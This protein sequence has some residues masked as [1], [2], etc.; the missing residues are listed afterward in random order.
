SDI[1][2]IRKKHLSR[3]GG[4]SYFE[5]YENRFDIDELVI[6]SDTALL[7]FWNAC[8]DI[9]SDL[10]FSYDVKLIDKAKYDL[11]L[12]RLRGDAF[13]GIKQGHDFAIHCLTYFDAIEI[14]PVMAR[15]LGYVPA[16]TWLKRFPE[17]AIS[18]L[19]AC[20]FNDVP[21]DR[22]DAQQ[23]LRWLAGQGYRDKIEHAAKSFGPEAH[24][25]A[26]IFLDR[27][28]EADFLPKKLAKL[29]AYFIA[30][31]HPA[32]ILKG[33]GKALPAHAVETIGR[34]M[35][36]S[37]CQLQTPALMQVMK[38]CDPQSLADFVLSAY[39]SWVKNGAKKDGI[40]F[41]HALGYVGD[42][43]VS[44]LLINTYKNAPFYPATAA[45]IEVLGA[46]GSNA[47][48]AGLLTIM[49]FSRYDKAQ[50]YA[51]EVLEGV[52]ES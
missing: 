46:L 39:D 18:G 6:C 22:R 42:A 27:S 33:T 35:L 19:L 52:A 29:P 38:A 43:Q 14:A 15:A 26:V 24:A 44:A 1:S 12:Y 4:L 32:P 49:R 11:A 9:Y 31:A 3:Q 51:Q 30:S 20:A 34:M 17:T 45:A 16:Q 25:A 5:K 7:E 48:I 36:A 47:A 28:D 8:F 50:A 10:L 40:G 21:S 41:L 37:T 23:A 2:K 13:G